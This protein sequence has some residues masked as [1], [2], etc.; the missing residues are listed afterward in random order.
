MKEKLPDRVW[1]QEINM[2]AYTL[3]QLNQEQGKEFLEEI[4]QRIQMYPGEM[5]NHVLRICPKAAGITEESGVP[6]YYTG[7]NLF[8]IMEYKIRY[9]NPY[10]E[11]YPHAHI[12]YIADDKANTC[13]NT[14]YISAGTVRTCCVSVWLLL[15]EVGLIHRI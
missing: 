9:T 8:D 11:Y 3:D 10:G 15:A 7:E 2:L 14:Y 1:A 6:P 5:L 12:E 13:E 4:A